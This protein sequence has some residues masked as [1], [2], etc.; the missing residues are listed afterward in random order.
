MAAP[1]GLRARGEALLQRLW[2]QP[3]TAPLAWALAPLAWLHAALAACSRAL[4]RSGLRR[5]VRAPRPVVVV[6]NLV[7]GGAGK[8]PTVVAV[9]QALRRAGLSPGVVSRGHGRHSGRVAEVGAG[10]TAAEVGDE[11]LVIARRCGVPVVVGRRRADA[12]RALCEAHPEVDVIVADDGLQHPALAR[13]V[14]VVV[15][16]GRGIGNGWLLPAGPLRE[17]PAAALGR[18]VLYNAPAPS[19]P[20]PGAVAT[21]RLGPAVPLGSWLQGHEAGAVPLD[22]LAGR[23]AWAAAGIAEPERFF[24]M[25]EAAG[26][27]IRRLPLPDHH[28]YPTLP[29]PDA[30]EDVLVTEKDA[31]KLAGRPVGAARVWVVGLD[32]A[33]PEDFVRELLR[34]LRAARAS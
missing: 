16:D 6:G 12:A 15:F 24:G 28:D 25:L 26:L 22:R 3:R 32:L 9:V 8:T 19:T 30:A 1:G 18:L 2:W 23:P 13:D 27:S 21:R 14:E 34:R 17:R 10:S 5:P 33:L 7:V 20:V 29:W 4:W 11:P 31:V